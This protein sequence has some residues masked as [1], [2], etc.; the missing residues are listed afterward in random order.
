MVALFVILTIVVFL[1]IDFFV[2][3][4]ESA[5]SRAAA[6]ETAGAPVEGQPVASVPPMP[7]DRVPRGVFLGPGHV[8][9]EVVPSGA[10]RVGA[11]MF[12]AAL[13]GKPD[14]IEVGK[15]GTEVRRG[16]V[17]AT[18]RRGRRTLALRSPVDGVITGVNAEAQGD[19]GRLHRDPFGQGWL[20]WL[21]PKDLASALKR[22]L[23]AEDATTW[24]RQ[25]LQKLR[26]FLGAVPNG[27]LAGATLHDGGV[28]VEGVSEHLDDERWEKLLREIFREER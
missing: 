3:R 10:L 24:A 6:R 21:S 27:V 14:R 23:V 15:T 22:M 18:L 11:D 17:I 12:A 25:Q 1:T 2:L 26:D 28:P 5:K 16:E 20:L 4:A 19:P 7:I 8:W 13:L 9:L